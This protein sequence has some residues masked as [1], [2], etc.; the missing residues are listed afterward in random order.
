[1]RGTETILENR[2]YKKT[3]FE[4]TEEQA[5]LF[6]RNKETCTPPPTERASHITEA[7]D[8][9]QSN[10][11]QYYS[12]FAIVIQ[13]MMFKQMLVHKLFV[14]RSDA[15]RFTA[16]IYYSL[17]GGNFVKI[18]HKCH[19]INSNTIF[20]FMNVYCILVTLPCGILGQVWYLIVSFPDLCRLSYFQA[21]V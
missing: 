7:T 20:V 1:M 6:Q 16:T 3:K 8:Y 19:L 4:G 9:H 15:S 17:F 5:N 21:T 10:G 2:E 18:G 14:V 12:K 13:A 11:I